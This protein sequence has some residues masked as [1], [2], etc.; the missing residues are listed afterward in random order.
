MKS[1][2]VRTVTLLLLANDPVRCE[3]ASKVN[4][5]SVFWKALGVL[6]L[7]GGDI[8]VAMAS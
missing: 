6:H 1:E 4:Q 3:I 2:K 8:R 5:E 7:F